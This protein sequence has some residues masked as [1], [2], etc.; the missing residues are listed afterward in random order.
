MHI[1]LN[2]NDR[3]WSSADQQLSRP[4]HVLRTWLQTDSYP[5]RVV[6]TGLSGVGQIPGPKIEKRPF[7]TW[8]SKIGRSTAGKGRRWEWL[9]ASLMESRCWQRGCKNRPVT[10]QGKWTRSNSLLQQGCV[11]NRHPIQYKSTTRQFGGDLWQRPKA[12]M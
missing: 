4:S 3:D 2:V 11:P 7:R 5:R 12:T 9:Y 8:Q 10:F 1:V 6:V